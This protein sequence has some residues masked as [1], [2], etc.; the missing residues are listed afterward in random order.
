MKGDFAD[1]LR[2]TRDGDRVALR[3][4]IRQ[5]QPEVWLLCALLV[6]PDDASDATQHTFLRAHRELAASGGAADARTWLLA[7]AH[8][9]C[10]DIVKHKRG[11]RRR[12]RRAS[13]SA[14]AT[15]AIERD[16]PLMAL[17][18]QVDLLP[19]DRRVAWVL[20]QALGLSYLEIG[21]VCRWPVE[22]VRSRVA[23]AR[24]AL[25]ARAPAAPISREDPS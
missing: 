16:Y 10:A 18:A 8:K 3:A 9:T 13:S 21:E 20:T 14:R 2:A 11:R 19:Y 7:I 5:A 4:W 1:L 17:A 24:A 6:G 23:Q 12:R 15:A 25:L 22:T